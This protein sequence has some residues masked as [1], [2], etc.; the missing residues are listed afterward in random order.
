MKNTKISFISVLVV[1]T[2]SV[3]LSLVVESDNKK[4]SWSDNSLPFVEDE[5]DFCRIEIKKGIM[6]MNGVKT[7]FH[8]W[9]FGSGA[10]IK[11]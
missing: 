8:K 4:T 7:V 2:L 1:L 10:P 6:G 9:I 3:I 11:G 5:T